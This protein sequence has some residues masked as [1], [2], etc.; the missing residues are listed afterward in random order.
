[1]GNHRP[2]SHGSNITTST[3]KIRTMARIITTFTDCL[4]VPNTIGIGPIRRRPAP[5]PE[6]GPR[7]DRTTS[8]TV[9]SRAKTNPKMMSR[10]PRLVIDG[11]FIALAKQLDSHG[12]WA[13]TLPDFVG[14]IACRAVIVYKRAEATSEIS[15]RRSENNVDFGPEI[16]N[17]S[18]KLS[19]NGRRQFPFH[20]RGP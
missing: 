11:V 2:T 4:S 16:G 13:L 3:S 9:A 5:R 17:S 8:R 19:L 14:R 18:R 6:P 15:L 12:S 10:K 1:M 20:A 7:G